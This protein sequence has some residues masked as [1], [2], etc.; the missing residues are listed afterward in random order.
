MRIIVGS[1][2]QE[3]HSFSPLRGEMKHFLT[4]AFERGQDMLDRSAGTRTEVAGI[5]AV[6]TGRGATLV[7]LLRAMSASSNGPIERATYEEIRD[8]LLARLRYELAERPADGV[9]LALHGA[10][11]AEGYDDATGDVLRAVRDVIGPEVPMVATL[12][13]HANITRRMCE[14][15]NAL[16]GYRT[17][18]HIDLYET[19]ERA[20]HVLL[21]AV[22][23]RVEPVNVMC[24]LPMIVPAENA[25]T[26]HGVIFDLMRAAERDLTNPGILDISFFPMQPWL[27]LPDAGCAVVVVADS[28]QRPD[29]HGIAER[30]AAEWWRRKDEH[31]VALAVTDHAIAEALA[32]ERRPWVFADSADAP[33]SGAPGDSPFTLVALVRAKPDRDCLTNI[34][35]PAAVEQIFQAGVGAEVTVRLGACSGAAVYQPIEV[36]GR[37]RLLSDG[38]FVHRG[39][40]LRGMRM[41]RGRTA[42][43]QVGGVIVVVMERACLQ[44]DRALYTSL[45]LMP[46]D[47]QIVIVKSPA[48]FRADYEPIAAEVRVLDSPGVCTPNL[49]SLPYRRITHP[50]YPFD[51]EFALVTHKVQT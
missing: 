18:P 20:M 30:L 48:G 24:K 10:M 3:S 32:S 31:S 11:V 47:A 6:A 33:S 5:V 44:W 9:I 4:G 35:D 36:S 16:I 34:V 25:Q 26:T 42:V 46:E 23:K 8:E 28:P 39:P 40:G 14:A 22:E 38:D 19:G 12:D 17:F 37:V 1:F 13:L 21:D 51:G 7:P 45:G 43:L 27:D 49:V 2:V 15:S 50:L 41:H 29:A